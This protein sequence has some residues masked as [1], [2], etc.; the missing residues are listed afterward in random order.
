MWRTLTLGTLAAVG[1]SVLSAPAQAQVQWS[2]PWTYESTLQ[3]QNVN[4]DNIVFAENGDIVLR[5]LPVSGANIQ[6]NRITPAGG[7]RWSANL[8]GFAADVLEANSSGPVLPLD[9]GGAIVTMSSYYG[10]DQITRLGATGQIIWSRGIPSGWQALAGSDRVVYAGCNIVSMADLQSGDILW[11]YG[12]YGPMSCNL[13][14]GAVDS[15][16]NVYASFR[17][18]PNGSA[19]GYQLSKFQLD[20]SVLWTKSAESSNWA[21]VIGTDGTIL[22]VTIGTQLHALNSADGSPK[23]VVDFCCGSA[24]L[25]VNSNPREPI[26][27]KEDSVSRLDRDDG[28][29]R[30]TTPITPCGESV[31]CIYPSFEGDSMLLTSGAFLLR[32]GL[33]NGETLWSSAIPTTDGHGNNLHWI[34]FGGLQNGYIRGIAYAYDEF[35]SPFV[36]SM[37]F[38]SGQ[39]LNTI[40]VQPTLHGRRKALSSVVQSDVY[41][42]SVSPDGTE[43]GTRIRRTEGS[44]GILKWEVVRSDLPPPYGTVSSSPKFQLSRPA[45]N[46]S[47]V[48]NATVWSTYI[49]Q[50]YAGAALISAIDRNTG[51]E[52][53]NVVISEPRQGSTYTSDPVLDQDGNVFISVGTLRVC[54]GN[55]YCRHRILY[56]LSGQSGAI[57]WQMDNGDV[58]PGA[59][60]GGPIGEVDPPKFELFNGDVVVNGPFPGSTNTLRRLS[61]SDGSLIWATDVLSGVSGGLD[62]YRQDDSHIIARDLPH[63]ARIDASTGATLWNADQEPSPA[64]QQSC[65]Q[66]DEHV[67]ANGNLLRAGE[68]NSMPALT[69]ARNDGSGDIEA[70]TLEP[71]S[72]TLRSTLTRVHTTP[73]GEIRLKLNRTQRLAP[74]RLEVLAGF[75]LSSGSLVSQQV[76]S[77][78]AIDPGDNSAGKTPLAYPAQD[79]M[80]FQSLNVSETGPLS[81]GSGLLDTS[82]TAQGDLQLNANIQDESVHAG[83]WLGFTLTVQYS[84]EAPINGAS[85]KAGTL[86]WQGALRN[87]DCI[88]QNAGNC[89]LDDRSG[90][91]HATFDI[92]PGGSVTISGEMRVLV[93][94]EVSYFGGVV[95]G[96]VGLSESDTINNFARSTVVQSLF[97]DG[98]ESTVP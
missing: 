57:L 93:N 53:W 88:T 76:L 78:S 16:G 61:G 96:P 73:S 44:T 50:S 83:N 70:W 26:I 87:L 45:S 32:I 5:N 15:N 21:R 65:Y 98:F 69:L 52:L 95:A 62:F 17:T 74:G 14:S 23:W 10:R 86:P 77:S 29:E 38:A 71:N 91:V 92:Q 42:V 63:L 1:L 80:L 94:D 51:T 56:K 90:N 89:V 4:Q 39:L 85:L 6:A 40:P 22:Y 24:Y 37:D 64:C 67:L 68:A 34:K 60:R 97:A 27:V 30:W 72:A 31:N 81:G 47:L 43:Y 82:I 49:A 13:V 11:Q 33:T 28:S 58:S 59:E 35:S 25:P 8:Y 84:G 3:L 12:L 55:D 20:G 36:Q 75:D 18:K 9:D 19:D 41:D 2:N 48:V 79:R 66:Y 46:T 7:V 54:N